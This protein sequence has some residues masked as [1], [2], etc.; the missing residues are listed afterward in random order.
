LLPAATALLAAA[1][2][3]LI[4]FLRA[5]PP[6]S[7]LRLYLS[8][9]AIAWGACLFGYDSSYIVRLSFLSGRLRQL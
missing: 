2:A 3:E 8:A 6:F 4:P 5:E 9:L 7:S 1:A